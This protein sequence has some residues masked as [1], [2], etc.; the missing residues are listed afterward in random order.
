MDTPLSSHGEEARPFAG[1]CTPMVAEVLQCTVCLGFPSTTNCRSLDATDELYDAIEN[2][3]E[4]EKVIEDLQQEGSDGEPEDSLQSETEYKS[5]SDSEKSLQSRSEFDEFQENGEL[6]ESHLLEIEKDLDDTRVVAGIE[7][8]EFDDLDEAEIAE[9]DDLLNSDISML[10]VDESM[11]QDD[12]PNPDDWDD[13]FDK[14]SES[15]LMK[16]LDDLDKP[17]DIP[18]KADESKESVQYSSTE[19]GFDDQDMEAIEKAL[20]NDDFDLDG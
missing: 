13:E 5:E 10:E 9:L 20:K 16:L 11:L 7:M 1:R 4:W 3:T 18:H 6:D 2:I 12:L 14:V 8:D 19:C 17:D 15:D